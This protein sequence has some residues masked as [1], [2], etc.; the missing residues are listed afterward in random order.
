MATAFAILGMRV[1]LS[2]PEFVTIMGGPALRF[3]TAV[4]ESQEA[5]ITSEALDL[6][7]KV[8]R[9][10]FGISGPFLGLSGLRP[11]EGPSGS[12][13]DLGG[14]SVECPMYTTIAPSLFSE[15]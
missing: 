10:V 7:N 4:F 5:M 2:V 3:P 11:R 12:F 13:A 14:V 1:T 15:F 9:V 6:L 8:L